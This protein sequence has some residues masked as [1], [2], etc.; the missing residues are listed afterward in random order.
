MAINPQ[1][2]VIKLL[3]DEEG[4]A[5]LPLTSIDAVLG[6]DGET[7]NQ[8]LDAKIGPSDIKAGNNVTVSTSGNTVTINAVVPTVPKVINNVTT[9]SSGQGVLDAYQGKVLNDKIRQ[10]E[11][12]I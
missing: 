2:L 7:F 6:A 11:A 1:D 12:K 3:R 8:A 5:F 4:E 10:I 9:S